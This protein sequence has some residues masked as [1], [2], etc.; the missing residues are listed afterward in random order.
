MSTRI[1]TWTALRFDYRSRSSG[2]GTFV[3]GSFL[4]LNRTEMFSESHGR[5][6]YGGRRGDIGGPFYL[7]QDISTF[8]TQSLNGSLY[9]G[10][11]TAGQST[12]FVETTAPSEPT[13]ASMNASG[14]TA[15]SR[16]APTNPSFS[17]ATAIG[18]LREEFP[19]IVGTSV[20]KE[21]ARYL[22]NSGDEYL[23]VQFGWAPMMNDLRSFARSVKRHNAIIRQ[24]RHGSDQKIR[25]RL[26][27]P[28]VSSTRT[29]VTGGILFPT[30]AN[31]S[32]VATISETMTDKTW[33]SGAF[34]YHI[35]IGDTTMEKME[36]WESLAN[37]LLGTRLT[38]DVVWNLA[39]WSW[40]IDWF[41]NAGDIVNNIALLGHDGLVLQYGYVMRHLRKELHLAQNVTIGG[42]PMPDYRHTVNDR[43]K[44]LPAT[45][46]GFGVDFASLTKTQTAIVAALGLTWRGRH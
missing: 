9:Q 36:R 15:I 35:P 17:A 27:F 14:S 20:L 43:K 5:G 30:A 19:H 39:P 31:Q 21:R 26:V 6:P 1:N 40:A 10:L 46:Y 13:D 38:P 24:Y 32:A 45:P 44:R 16:T 34:L 28:E 33:F 29:S 2:F 7:E 25:R 8:G 42:K 3:P 37:Q 11:I 12:T 41:S 22:Q 18:E 23:N 4:R